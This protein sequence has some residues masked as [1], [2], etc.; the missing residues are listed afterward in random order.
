MLSMIGA[1]THD[2][3]RRSF[4]CMGTTGSGKTEVH[5]RAGGSCRARGRQV[6]VLVPEINL[7]P[8]LEARFAERFGSGPVPGASC[9]CTA[10]AHAGAAPAPLAGGAPGLADL[11]LGTRLAVFAPAAP[12]RLSSS[13]TRS[14]TRRKQ[15][16]GARYWPATRRS[17]RPHRW[18][19]QD[20]RLGDAVAESWQ[21]AEQGAIGAFEMALRIGGGERCLRCA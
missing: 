1:M 14:T 6:L 5:L 12:A 4:R 11:V 7:T 8:Q 19:A 21:R 10:G 18:G 16:E 2:G 9:R 3:K 17:P 15:Q 13:S 20:P